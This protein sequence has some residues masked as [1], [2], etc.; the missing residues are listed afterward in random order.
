MP[1]LGPEAVARPVEQVKRAEVGEAVP[2]GVWWL[3]R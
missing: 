2:M 3:T 1:G